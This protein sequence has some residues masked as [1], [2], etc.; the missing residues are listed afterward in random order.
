MSHAVVL[1]PSAESNRTLQSRLRRLVCF[2]PVL[3]VLVIGALIVVRPRPPRFALPTVWTTE[4]PVDRIL[5]WSADGERIYLSKKLSNTP[6]GHWPSEVFAID[7]ATGQPIPGRRV[8]HER[9]RVEDPSTAVE[10]PDGRLLVAWPE[11]VC[12]V[13]FDRPDDE[14]WLPYPDLCYLKAAVIA[15]IEAGERD[16][17]QTFGELVGDP[18]AS[19]QDAVGA[20]QIELVDVV[21]GDGWVRATYVRRSPTMTT[22]AQYSTLSGETAGV[23]TIELNSQDVVAEPL[24]NLMQN[25]TPVR[26]RLAPNGEVVTYVNA[27]CRTVARNLT[28]GAETVLGDGASFTSGAGGPNF[29]RTTALPFY[30]SNHIVDL[31]RGQVDL[32]TDPT[33]VTLSIAINDRGLTVSPQQGLVVSA[34]TEKYSWWLPSQSVFKQWL[35][36]GF[37]RPTVD[38]KAGGFGPMAGAAKLSTDAIELTRELI[39]SR[40]STERLQVKLSPDGRFLLAIE[41][42]PDNTSNDPTPVHLIE[43][44]EFESMRPP[45]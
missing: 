34:F 11:G 17:D 10:L 45:E 9:G 8:V 41:G 22:L 5:H 6:P 16:R 25:W 38:S 29:A 12:L 3:I 44:D 35:H 15:E 40:H 43:T 32:V 7:A 20:Y 18:E 42:R 28:S 27:Q 31:E 36:L 2:R 14:V 13:N 39:P 26:P 21:V 4:L 19:R 33:A 30:D 37:V 23:I 24:P 1:P